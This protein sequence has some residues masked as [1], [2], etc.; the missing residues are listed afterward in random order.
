VTLVDSGV[1]DHY[2]GIVVSNSG[3]AFAYLQLFWRTD[4]VVGS[5][6]PDISIGIPAGGALSLPINRTI[7]TGI[8]CAF[9]GGVENAAAPDGPATVVLFPRD[10]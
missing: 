8:A 1:R 9:T 10:V 7:D 3:T 6:S 4:A 2:D 5:D